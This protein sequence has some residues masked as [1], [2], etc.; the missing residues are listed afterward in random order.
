MLFRDEQ[1]L[2]RGQPGPVVALPGI[3]PNKLPKIRIAGALDLQRD[4]GSET[5]LGISHPGDMENK[6]PGSPSW[7]IS[8]YGRSDY[9]FIPQG[10]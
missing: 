7:E 3:Q 5:L 1:T 10:E 4:G 2:V 6:T 9:F 8:G